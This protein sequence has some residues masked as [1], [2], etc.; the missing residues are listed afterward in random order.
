MKDKLQMLAYNIGAV[1]IGLVISGC[2]LLFM[3]VDPLAVCAEALGKI[4]SDRYTL[5]EILVKASP[6]IFTSLAFAFTYKANLFN[7]GAQGQ[8]YAG[9]DRR[10][11]GF[12]RNRG[13]RA[14]ARRPAVLLCLRVCRRRSHWRANRSGKGQIRRK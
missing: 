5:G 12:S 4:F 1:L 2:M 6:L 13:A 11:Y 9:L 8:F 14:N 3:K 7:I 10:H